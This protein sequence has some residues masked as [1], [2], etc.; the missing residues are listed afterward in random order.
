MYFAT[1]VNGRDRIS[2]A[3]CSDLVAHV[4]GVEMVGYPAIQ[5]W[6]NGPTTISVRLATELAMHREHAARAIRY[7]EEAGD[8]LYI[9]GD[10]EIL[11]SD[12]YEI[13]EEWRIKRGSDSDRRKSPLPNLKGWAVIERGRIDFLSWSDSNVEQRWG[14]MENYMKD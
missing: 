7:H 14:I 12:L 9:G 1:S 8:Q 3:P 13:D 2:D 5:R 4:R 11:R 10:L 6:K